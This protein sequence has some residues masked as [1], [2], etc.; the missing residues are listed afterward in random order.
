[1]KSTTK[2][3]LV[4]LLAALVAGCAGE[5]TVPED[6]AEVEMPPAEATEPEDAE[7]AEEAME[8]AEGEVAPESVEAGDNPIPVPVKEVAAEAEA[9]VESAVE[10]ARETVA[11]TVRD[12]VADV[13]GPIEVAATKEGLSRIGAAKCKL[14]HKIQYASWADSSHAGLDPVLDCESCHGPGSEYKKMS[15][16]K[17]RDQALAAGL[18]LPDAAFCKNCHTDDWDDGMLQAAHEH[19]QAS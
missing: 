5:Q 16:M 1:M 13:A 10:S 12:A 15:I 4:L 8:V 3:T 9:A 18:V 19:K 11:E 6:V 2:L 7:A 14:C 17:N